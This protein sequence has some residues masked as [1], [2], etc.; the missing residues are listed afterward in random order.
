M[1]ELVISGAKIVTEQGI[2]ERGILHVKDGFIVFVGDM[3]EWDPISCRFC[4]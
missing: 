4:C 3:S 1:S 2:I